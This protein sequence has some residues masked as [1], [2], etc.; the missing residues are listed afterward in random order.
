GGGLFITLGDNTEVDAFNTTLHELL[1][2][3]LAVV[4]TTG[5]LRRAGQAAE[6]AVP[7]E[8]ESALT[9][10]GEH[11]GRMDRRHPLLLPFSSGRASESLL[12]AR[13][14]R[15]MLLRPTPRSTGDSGGVILSYE[16][17]APALIERQLGRGRVL[18]FTSTID[19]DWNNLPIQPAFL[20][21]LQQTVR[22][23]SHA[24]LR[25]SEP[26]TTIGQP[27]DIRLQTG[28]T[29]VEISL[30]SGKKRL[31]ERLGGRQ[32]L[33]FTDTIEPGFYRV[34][35]A[36]DSGV[37]RPRPA[38]FFVVNIEPSEADL[39]PPPPSRLVALQ[40]TL[41]D[42]GAGTEGSGAPKRQVELWHY[43][44]AL[45]LGLILGE[46]LLLRQK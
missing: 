16:S 14:G 10:P 28:D 31:F 38:E 25:D 36:G 1:P 39:Q 45:L 23:L 8:S 21:L 15:Y 40:R 43:L 42:S 22:Y 6:A 5:P 7:G 12:E 18:L 26:A 35:A 13:F 3:A 20:P 34:A 46:A 9:G 32:V 37:L 11:L 41:S 30:P 4:K 2:Q 19:R 17:G 44:G 27:R 24:P 33:T 29:R